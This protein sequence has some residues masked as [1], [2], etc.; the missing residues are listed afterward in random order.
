MANE[1]SSRLDSTHLSMVS[2]DRVA[3]VAFNALDRIQRERPELLTAAFALLFAVVAERNQLDPLSLFTLGRRLLHEPHPNHG[4]PTVQL[5]SL[6][7]FAGL[8]VRNKPII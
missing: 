7:D 8:R 2:R 6:R 5:E 3:D 4:H 1:L